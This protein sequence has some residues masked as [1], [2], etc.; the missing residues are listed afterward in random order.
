[1][2]KLSIAICDDLTEE[3]IQLAKLVY[4]YGKQH[5]LHLHIRLFSSGE[6]LL[7][8]F[9]KPGQFQIIF[10]DIYMP[11]HSGIDTARRIRTFDF[12]VPILF[13]TTS[14]DHGLDSFE[15]R[16][17]DYL[18]K[19]LQ[20]DDVAHALD[21]CLEHLP[22]PLRCLSILSEWEHREI[23][24][25]S[26]LYIDVYGHQSCIHTEHEIVITRRGLDDLANA[27][28]SPDFLRCHRSVLVNMNHIQALEGNDFRMSNNSLVPISSTNR[29]SIRSQFLDWT[30]RKAWEQL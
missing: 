7:N 9:S 10:L 29:T 2:L 16:A 1:M 19:P 26:I 21:W 25:F 6:E 28:D 12:H 17:S 3:R 8:L 5:K 11:G 24:L 23:P 27:I 4:Q 22:E 30:Y 15:V 14:Q 20:A 18:V 13:A